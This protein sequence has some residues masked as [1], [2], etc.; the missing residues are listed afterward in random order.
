MT[1]H[2]WQISI[3]DVLNEY[4]ASS[5]KPD[6][7][8][9]EAWIQRYPQFKQELIEYTIAWSL[10]E[11]LPPHPDV[12]EVDQETL[13]LRGMSVVKNILHQK[14]QPADNASIDSLL[15]EGQKLGFDINNLADSSWLS[16][17]LFRKL[18]LCQFLYMSI[19]KQAIQ[20]IAQT[21]R[22]SETVV[23]AYL[24]QPKKSAKYMNYR[25]TSRPASNQPQEDF[26]EAV[27]GD[28]TL[29][30][31]KR[32]YWSALKPPQQ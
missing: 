7:V 29:D 13:T 17:R 21:L 3:E 10:M 12:E 32:R 14:D 4:V 19:P 24:Q 1:Y 6:Q 26:F 5:A 9:L 8:H 28:P 25:A 15:K 31:E 22:C 20:R 11:Q 27:D 16:V 23:D 2:E 30:E 18:D